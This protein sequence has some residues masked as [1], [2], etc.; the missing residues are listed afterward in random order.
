MG[1]IETTDVTSC[2]ATPEVKPQKNATKREQHTDQ[3]T[4]K[5]TIQDNHMVQPAL[6][7]NAKTNVASHFLTLIDKHFP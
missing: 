7:Q 6:Q 3:K 4:E 1:Y 2:A 5:K